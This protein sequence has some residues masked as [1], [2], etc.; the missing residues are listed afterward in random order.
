[1]LDYEEIPERPGWGAPQ[2]TWGPGLD[3]GAMLWCPYDTDRDMYGCE[4]TLDVTVEDGTGRS[5]EKRVT[6]VPDCPV[7][8]PGASYVPPEDEQAV[9]R[10]ECAANYDSRDCNDLDPYRDRAPVCTAP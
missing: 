4:W 10:C 1:M 7:D 8:D 9:C 3:R 2:T 5:A 6:V